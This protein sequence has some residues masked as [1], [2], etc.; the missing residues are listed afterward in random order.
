MTDYV[1]NI[2][3]IP[4]E[5]SVVYSKLS[6]LRGLSHIA[7]ALKHAQESKVELEVVDADTIAFQIP[8]AGKLSLK[9]VDR[10]PEG[11]IKLE[12]QQSPLP[13]TLWIQL[14]EPAPADTRL[15]LTLR[16]ELNFLTKQLVGSKLEEGVEKLADILASIPYQHLG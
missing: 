15:R 9:I 14:L 6:D 5:R 2:K 1:S 12:A 3:S 4:A 13:I 11:T 7:E 10:E 16:T 8:M